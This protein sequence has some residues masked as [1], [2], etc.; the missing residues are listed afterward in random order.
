M[1]PFAFSAGTAEAGS[2]L[3]VDFSALAGCDVSSGALGSCAAAFDFREVTRRET[4]GFS[5]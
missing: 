1:S 4:R 3:A 2:M 5:V